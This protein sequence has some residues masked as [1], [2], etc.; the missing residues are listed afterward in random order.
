M[1]EEPPPS[2][3]RGSTLLYAA[4]FTLLVG[5]VI[6]LGVSVA[7]FLESTALLISSAVMSGL[8]LVIAVA[9]VVLPGRR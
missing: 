9:G 4:S 1:S 8:A 5:A 2:P 6:A 3:R 7:G